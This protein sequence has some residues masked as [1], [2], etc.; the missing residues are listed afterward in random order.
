M[1]AYGPKRTS[2]LVQE[3]CNLRYTYFAVFSLYG[4]VFLMTFNQSAGKGCMD[5]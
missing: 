1:S 4:A 2:R 3:A 5:A